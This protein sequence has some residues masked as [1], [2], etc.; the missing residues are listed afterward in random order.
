MLVDVIAAQLTEEVHFE[1][2]Y[3]VGVYGCKNFMGS[4]T[5]IIFRTYMTKTILNT[6]SHRFGGLQALNE[7]TVAQTEDWTPVP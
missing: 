6:L 3:Q 5:L 1:S 7:V 2:Q 4:K